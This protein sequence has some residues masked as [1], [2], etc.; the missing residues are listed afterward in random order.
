MLGQGDENLI[1]LTACHPKYSARQRII[2]QAE[3]V[4]EPAPTIPRDDA[5]GLDP[6]DLSAGAE[7][8]RAEEAPSGADDVE[9]VISDEVAADDDPSVDADGNEVGSIAE[10][11]VADPES[12][13]TGD[14]ADAATTAETDEQ[15]PAADLTADQIELTAAETPF[16]S[17]DDFGEGLNGDRTKVTPAIMWGIAAMAVWLATWFV[18]KRLNR[19]WTLYAIGLAPFAL[20]LWSCFVNVDQALP[21]Y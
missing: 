20:L 4:G 7:D 19:K 15:V 18:G 16:E 5:S 2:V 1:T 10:D 9:E 11:D 14:D 6:V 17:A 13:T 12:Q 8:E 3:L 21:S